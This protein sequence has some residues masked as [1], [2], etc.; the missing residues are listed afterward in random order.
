MSKSALSKHLSHLA[1]TGY[2]R[3]DRAVRNFR[4]RLWPSLTPARARAYAAQ[5]RAQQII[6]TAAS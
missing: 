2:V 6:T 3:Q 1:E 4:S 5:V